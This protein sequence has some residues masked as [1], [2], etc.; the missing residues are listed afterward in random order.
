[1]DCETIHRAVTGA[2]RI[3]QKRANDVP[4]RICGPRSAGY[5]LGKN[6]GRKRMKKILIATTSIFGLLTVQGFPARADQDLDNR[7]KDPK[8]W[9]MK[10]GDNANLRY[11]K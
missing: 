1:M 10:Q 11:C 8:Q 9:V 3:I 4:W 5:P 6:P 7:A 2:A